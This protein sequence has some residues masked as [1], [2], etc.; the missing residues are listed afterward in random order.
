MGEKPEEVAEIEETA[1]VEEE[2]T[3]EIEETSRED[4]DLST[5]ERIQHKIDEMQEKQRKAHFKEQEK[6]I[7]D[8]KCANCN[9]KK[10]KPVKSA[11]NRKFGVKPEEYMQLGSK[12]DNYECADC[13]HITYVGITYNVDP[14]EN[15]S[16]ELIVQDKGFP[17]QEY[18]PN[19]LSDDHIKGWI[20]EQAELVKENQSPLSTDLQRI[21][22]GLDLAL[23]K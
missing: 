2:S 10:I 23:N 14:K 7:K 11:K 16:A 3:E 4:D 6:E 19:D 15:G 12:A 17:W 13:G 20:H 1:P 8:I 18:M 21:V 22:R 5:S 9:S